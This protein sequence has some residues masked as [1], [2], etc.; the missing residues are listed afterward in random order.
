MDG[1]GLSSSG[2][3]SES[4]AKSVATGNCAL[5]LCGVGAA[6]RCCEAATLAMPIR[7]ITAAVRAS[8]S[9]NTTYATSSNGSAPMSSMRSG[10]PATSKLCWR[11]S[12]CNRATSSSMAFIKSADRCKLLGCAFTA[13][14]NTAAAMRWA[15]SATVAPGTSGGTKGKSALAGSAAKMP[16]CIAAIGTEST[17]AS[18]RAGVFICP[19]IIA[20]QNAFRPQLNAGY[21]LMTK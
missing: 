15:S 16:P 3:F 7:S 10:K 9:A 11:E 2:G 13:S 4:G 6:A 1:A 20:P 14:H 19:R 5:A 18:S 8:R 17:T 12:R 21:P